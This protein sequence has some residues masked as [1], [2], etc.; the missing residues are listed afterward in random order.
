M[1]AIISH[2]Y[3]KKKR[4]FELFKLPIGELL[5]EAI[6]S[7]ELVQIE[8]IRSKVKKL[9]ANFIL[10]KSQDL[11]FRRAFWHNLINLDDVLTPFGK[12]IVKVYLTL[13]KVL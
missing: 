1:L 7:L 8:A 6:K 9:E 12:W 2:Q 13:S 5:Q 3:L 11:S 4:L 10:A